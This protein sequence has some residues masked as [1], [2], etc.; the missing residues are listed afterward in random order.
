MRRTA[1]T[2]LVALVMAT[3]AVG[4]AFAQEEGDTAATE[5]LSGVL[6]TV[7]EDPRPGSGEEADVEYTLTEDSG[8]KTELLVDGGDVEGE[9]GGLTALDGERVEVEA[10]E[11]PGPAVEVQEI[12]PDQPA[13]TDRVVAQA[14]A[15]VGSRPTATI[16]CRFSDIA[17]LPRQKA[18]FETLMG[19]TR[20]GLDQYWQETTY[21]KLNLAGSGV[22]GWYNLPN[23]ESYYKDANGNMQDDRLAQ[24]CTAAADGDV[25]F[26]GYTNINVMVNTLYADYA[27][28]GTYT[29]NRDGQNR[30]YGFT[31]MPRWG[32]QND[33]VYLGGQY[34]LAHEM[35]HSFGLP[36]SSGPHGDT[37]DSKWD[38]MSGGSTCSPEDAAFGCIATHT[39]A[40]HKDKAG[41]LDA[42]RKYAATTAA[43]QTVTLERMAQPGTTGYLMAKIP[44]A[45][46]ST[47]F[48]TVEARRLVGYDN[49]TPAD[50][51][52]I[53]KV[54]TTNAT[55]LT[56][57]AT[58]VDPNNDGNKNV[59]DASARWLPGETFTDAANNISV[60]VDASTSSGYAVTINPSSTPSPLSSDDTTAPTGS[61]VI[62]DGASRTRKAAVVL[63]LSAADNPGGTGVKEMRFSNDG[64]NWSAWEPYA[65]RKSWTLPAGKGTKTVYAEFRDGADNVSP[66][67]S[68]SIYKRR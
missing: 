14:A 22:F 26:P 7:Y 56:P 33:P 30:T 34:I 16:L 42:S 6:T 5:T 23:P 15:Q 1:Y 39:I 24:D 53:H 32:Y 29:L 36:H 38:V 40:A 44:I 13:P 18:H 65:P 45:G 3:L 27:Q 50:A 62:D 28:G 48:Y 41:W 57:I 61:V 19:S 46:S 17:D 64:T 2:M 9:K 60:R 20:P 21:G 49:Q 37:Y 63:S 68:D 4:T 12:S 67:T 52:I 51:V 25:F 59:N 11:A 35:G 43:N 54:D 10:A 47:R 31:W 55:G 66:R 8:Q 58:V